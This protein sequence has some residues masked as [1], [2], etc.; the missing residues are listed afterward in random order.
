MELWKMGV[1]TADRAGAVFTLLPFSGQGKIANIPHHSS[2]SDMKLQAKRSPVDFLPDGDPDKP[3]W[4]RAE[5]VEFDT[6]AS[7]NSHFPAISTRVSS[8]WTAKHIYFLFLAAPAPLTFHPANARTER[9]G[10]FGGL[11]VAEFCRTPQ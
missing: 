4:K 2:A 11:R 7:G 5:S 1:L 10:R 6:A 8:V 3:S 9:G